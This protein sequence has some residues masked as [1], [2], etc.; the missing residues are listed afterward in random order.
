MPEL[1]G[2]QLVAAP[3]IENRAQVFTAH[4]GRFRE[5]RQ[6]HSEAFK[7]PK[8]LAYPG[9]FRFIGSPTADLPESWSCLLAWA[10]REKG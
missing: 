2:L 9:F 8:G 5:V 3:P 1:G 4:C 6:R 10:V 7:L